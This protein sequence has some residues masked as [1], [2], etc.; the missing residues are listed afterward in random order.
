MTIAKDAFLKSILYLL[1]ETFEGSPEGQG[2]AYLDRGVGVFATLEKLSAEAASREISSTTIAAQTEHAKFYLDRLCEFMHG[3]TEKVNWEQSWLI[4][5][6]SET[7]W[8]AL[9]EGVRKSYEGALRCV[10]DIEDWSE[11]NVGMA[12]GILA[13]TAYHLGAIRQLAKS[14]GS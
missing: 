6:V 9:R 11:D 3:R 1:R 7:E 10:A 12:M 4:E 5:T 13:H 14:S 2:S 8:N